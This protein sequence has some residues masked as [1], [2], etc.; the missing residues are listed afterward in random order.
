LLVAVPAARL[1]DYLSAVD[2]AVHVGE[3]TPLGT[4]NVVVV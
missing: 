1:A 3:V 4:G 2:G